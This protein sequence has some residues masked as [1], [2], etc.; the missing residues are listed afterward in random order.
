MG[1]RSAVGVYDV[2]RYAAP[3]LTIAHPSAFP[4]QVAVR[5]MIGTDMKVG[6][7]LH[8]FIGF[9]IPVFAV[10]HHVVA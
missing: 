3:D 10:R 9:I 5:S 8:L 7:A 4:L 6:C 2:F 1:V